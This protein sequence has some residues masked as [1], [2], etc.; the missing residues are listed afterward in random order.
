MIFLQDF[1]PK[2]QQKSNVANDITFDET[3]DE[4]GQI[5]ASIDEEQSIPTPHS[6]ESNATTSQPSRSQNNLL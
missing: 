3:S 6:S 1:F 4:G 5:P 2:R